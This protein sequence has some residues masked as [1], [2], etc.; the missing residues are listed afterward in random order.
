[1][2]TFIE[3]LTNHHLKFKISLQQQVFEQ[4]L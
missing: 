1:V 4:N 2:I 3:V